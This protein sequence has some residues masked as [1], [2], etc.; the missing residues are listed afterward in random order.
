MRASTLIDAVMLSYDEPL[1]DHLH[2]RL[3]N[4]LGIRVKRLHG[5]HGMR[6]AYRLAAEVVDSEQFL[7]ADGDFAIDTGFSLS[8]VTPLGDADAMRVWRARNPVNGLE[9]GYG[10]LKLVRRSALRELGDTVDVLAALPGRTRFV[11]DVAGT[12]R[13]DQSPFHA[14]KAGFRE[15]AMLSR[16][17]EYGMDA[18]DGA[19][20]IAA[21]T[22]G[23]EGEFAEFALSGARAGASFEPG[24]HRSGGHR[25]R[26][27]TALARAH[28]NTVVAAPCGVAAD[29]RAALEAAGARIATPSGRP[30]LLLA[31]GR[32]A[33]AVAAAGRY[34]L[35]SRRW[36]AA[37]RRLPHQITLVARCLTEEACIRTGRRLG[38]RVTVVVLSASEALH[39]LAGL[40]SGPHTRIVHEVATTE[41][42]MLRLLG[43]L[44][45]RGESR[46]RLLAPTDGVRDALTA[47]FPELPVAVRPFAVADPGDRLADG[48]RR[49]ARHTFGIP[50]AETVVCLV[51]GWWPHKDIAVIDAALAQCDTSLHLLVA[52]APLDDRVIA[53]WRD[54]PHLRLQVVPGP[55]SEA[56]I[57]AVYATVVARR[58]GVGKE[59]GLVI[60][61]VRLG[62]PLLVS[63]H[64]RALTQALASQPW[65]CLFP[66]GDPARLAAAL[67][68]LAQMPLPGQASQTQPAS[69]CPPPPSSPPS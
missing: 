19:A 68:D 64:D 21:W 4:V 33:A 2:A 16:G 56:Q 11:A 50:A 49:Q 30:R 45:R 36:P 37:V 29:T 26:T 6:R 54:L 10:G 5:V 23:G 40:L 14:W 7:L 52:G 60:D 51:G 18:R 46:V 42:A 57:R 47:R 12:T 59:S 41:D 1:A 9:Y 3:Q 17:C 31:A 67:R 13:I 55:S 32:G 24:A 38:G 22:R 27:L 69:A 20:R 66:A 28:G 44:A 35:A 61:A 63:D 25:H 53:R 62:V 48:E 8:A 43:R 58:P 34:V 15:V 65:A 39:G